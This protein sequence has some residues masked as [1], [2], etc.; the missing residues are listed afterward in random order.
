MSLV[1]YNSLIVKCSHCGCIISSESFNNHECD[2]PLKNTKRIDV[3]HFRDD[4]FGNK[5]L[6]TGWGV[7]G[8]LYTF[9]VVPRKPIPI[10]FGNPMKVNMESN[11][12]E[13]LPE[14][15]R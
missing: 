2:L 9:E 6:M 10:V 13:K 12:D 1:S 11:P 4:S 5:K 3:I 8:T 14:P 15:T 7:D